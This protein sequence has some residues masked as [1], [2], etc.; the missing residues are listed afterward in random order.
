MAASRLQ[1]SDVAFLISHSGATKEILDVLRIAKTRDARCVA[2]TNHS[3][4]PIAEAAD[5]VLLT[6]VRE[7]MLATGTMQSEIAQLFVISLLY[8]AVAMKNVPDMLEK[9]V[10]YLE[11]LS[12]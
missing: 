10:G 12:D 5:I 4:S 2:L 11:A 3:R 7:P 1:K 6:A 9:E 8:V